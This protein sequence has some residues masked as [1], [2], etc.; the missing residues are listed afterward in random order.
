MNFVA[1]MGMG[2]GFNYGGGASSAS[3]RKPRDDAAMLIQQ[4]QAPVIS[5][6]CDI[7][8]L[9][10]GSPQ[11]GVATQYFVEVNGVVIVGSGLVTDT[12]YG[13]GNG[14]PVAK[15]GTLTSEFPATGPGVINV[16]DSSGNII[17]QLPILVVSF[18]PVLP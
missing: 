11:W 9:V 6:T 10:S 7:P 5:I 8:N 18:N 3:S 16:Q 17:G 2:A 1:R 13:S 12:A 4:H 14:P 15:I